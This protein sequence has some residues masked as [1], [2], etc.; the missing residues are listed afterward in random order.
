MAS[1]LQL[2]SIEDFGKR[3]C[4]FL[5][6]YTCAVTQGK[7]NLFS[8]N[9]QVSCCLLH[10]LQ[11]GHHT[12]HKISASSGFKAFLCSALAFF[13]VAMASHLQLCSIEDFGKRPYSFLQCY[14]CAVTQGKK[15]LFSGN[16]QVSCCLLHVLQLGHHTPHKISASSGFKAFLCSAL[17]FFIV[18]MASH[19]QLC[20]IEDFGKRPYSFLQC[21]TCAVTQGKKSLFSGNCQVS[22]CLLHVLQLGH[23]TPHKIS[24]SSGFKAFL[25][26]AF[27]FFIVAMASHLQLC[28]IEDFG[29]RPY[30]FLQCYTCAVTQGKKSLF[31]GNCQVSCCLL[32]V[33]QLGHHTP[34][35][36][37]ASS[38][39]KAFLCSALAFFIVAM[40]S[41][42]QLCSIEDFGK[43]PY[44][45]LQCYTC[46]VTQGKK[47]LFSGN[48]QVSCCLLHVLQLGHH[49]PHKI[50]ASS[51]FKAFLCSAF[52]FFIVAMASHLQLCSIEDFG[53][54]PYSFLQCYTCA[55]TQGKKSLFS[56]NCQVSC[57]LL[58]VLQLGHHTPHKISASS[59]FKAFLCSAL[60]FFI[61]A[62]AS[63]LQLCSIEDFGKRPYSF[64]QCYTCAVTH[65]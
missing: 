25:C 41:H 47:S 65:W 60:A 8:G 23:H 57:C 64:L 4:S 54:R 5:Q 52:A 63:H 10:V 61:V 34:H 55:V 17:A 28:S 40:A 14:T 27:A 6:C 15:S 33:L 22:C 32:H 9:C 62:M 35:K 51:G 56:G 2:C 13:I 18:A 43:R 39:F 37:S 36:I 44:S 29:K 53:K 31:S 38:G 7:K 30:S 11:L 46:A 26:S 49:T 58:H 16:C 3:P 24:A 12:P 1:H 50:S 20:S 19:L 48:C 21:Y 45:F 59:G 42:L